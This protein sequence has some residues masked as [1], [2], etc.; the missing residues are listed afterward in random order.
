[1]T[2]RMR[3]LPRFP[4]KISGTTGIKIERPA[5]TPDL[6]VSLD[7]SDIVRVPSVADNNK[8]FFI[9]WN[10]DL[11][12]YSIMSFADTF[13]AVVDTEGFM[14]QSVYDPQNRDADAFDRENHTGEQAASTITGLAGALNDI[15]TALGLRLRVD[16]AQAFNDAQKITA[17]ANIDVDKKV[18]YSAKA[19]NYTAV[20]ADKNGFLRFTSAATL[21]LD[22]AATLGA[23]WHVTVT[24][25][26]GDVTVDPNLS[27][28]INGVP[29]LTIPSGSSAMIVCDGATFF[30][31]MNPQ[32]WEVI[33][34]GHVVA[35]GVA[36]VNFTNLGGYRR[37]WIVG[38]ITPSGGGT[39]SFRTSTNNGASYD[40]GV[41]DY[42]H[43][44][45]QGSGAS[46]A[47]ARASASSGAISPNAS[48]ALLFSTIIEAFN[49]AIGCSA[50]TT[51]QLLSGG[52]VLLE[53]TTA[54]RTQATARN[55]L[56]LLTNAATFAC[57]ITL[58]GMRG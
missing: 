52:T 13:A 5:G 3:V 17:R 7:V 16:A 46:V 10:S 45:I 12:T 24:A 51:T 56:Q 58:L 43:Q 33:P 28:T 2:L 53:T 9:T 21:T 55:A 26:G 22:P 48:T 11:N 14:L 1:M 57:D 39:V 42:T 20:P 47:A 25:D 36:T 19:T 49:D 35:S 23:D 30:T 50:T 29:T 15:N 54:V 37:L 4:A 31:V 44:Y 34:G 27:E 38:R 41:S 40:S 8:V 32:G 6:V 18:V